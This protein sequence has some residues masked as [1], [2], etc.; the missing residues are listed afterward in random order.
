MSESANLFSS[1]QCL[2]YRNERGT[3]TEEM[4][5]PS[6]EVV[7]KHLRRVIKDTMAR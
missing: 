1:A 2:G 3:L 4:C 7:V 6:E 5:R